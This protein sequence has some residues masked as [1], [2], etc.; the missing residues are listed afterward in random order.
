MAKKVSLYGIFSALCIV[1]GYVEHFVSFDFLAPGIKIGLANTVALLLLAYGDIKGAF[2][3]NTV[4][5]L[6]SA[7][8]FSNPQTLIYSLSA[9]VISLSVM[10]IL[11]KTIKKLEFSLI[12]FSVI[13]ALVHNITQV[14]CAGLIIG[15]GVLYYLPFLIVAA[16]VSGI[17]TGMIANFILKRIKK[18]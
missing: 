17:I 7:F 5:I 4:R 1:L 16:V 6:L 12:G 9:G 18:F 15:K 11:I 8:L 14:I 10:S 2:L 3:V 13:G